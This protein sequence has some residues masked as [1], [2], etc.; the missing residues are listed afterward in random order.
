[1]RSY[2]ELIKLPTF[3]ERYRYL[4]LGGTVGESTFGH[5][6]YLNQIFYQSPEWRR[7]RRDVIVRDNGCDLAVPGWTIV[8]KIYIHHLNP[9]TLEDIERRSPAALDPENAVAV[10]F[11]THQAIHYGDE[12][13]LAIG[14]TER[15]PND[16]IPWR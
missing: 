11:G 3:E 12:S 9:I 6:R 7:F 4:K 2:S 1:M 16:T 5:A 15:K 14:F 10:S 8:D 13:L